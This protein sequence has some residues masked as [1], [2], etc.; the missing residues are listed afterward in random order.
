MA[1]IGAHTY[2]G[3]AFDAREYRQ[4]APIT[5]GRYCSIAD[6]V[7]ILNGGEHFTDRVSTYPFPPMG[8]G[9]NEPEGFTRGPVTIGNDVWIGARV[10]I[11]SG[12]TIGDGAV[13]GACSCVT[14]DVPAYAVA[15][16]VPA[17]V[18]RYRFDEDTRARLVA[19]RWWERTD[20]EV[21]AL[22]PLL[23]GT[24]ADALLRALE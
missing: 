16:G 1:T 19:S 10:T 6:D 8:M 22:A 14:R 15:S 3:H 12:V 2:H 24:D 18:R 13:I 23:E 17:K 4:G 9:G 7:L 21:R 11:L 20:R 5:I